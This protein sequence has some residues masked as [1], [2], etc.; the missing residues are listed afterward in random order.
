MD[1]TYA[2]ERIKEIQRQ[3]EQLEDS[4]SFIDKGYVIE[5]GKKYRVKL[6]SPDSINELDE[7]EA[8]KSKASSGPTFQVQLN[9]DLVK[10][11]LL[12]ELSELSNELELLSPVIDTAN[13]MVR[14]ALQSIGQSSDAVKP[15]YRGRELI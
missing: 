6:I 9:D 13:T 14:E 7:G 3:K 11:L 12:Q 2:V 15:T 5:K 1:I 4:L 10:Q 8:E